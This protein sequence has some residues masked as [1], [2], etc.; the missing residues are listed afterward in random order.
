MWYIIA[1]CGGFQ[2]QALIIDHLVNTFSL[3]LYR[4]IF[5]LLE[6]SSLAFA[7]KEQYLNNYK[8]LHHVRHTVG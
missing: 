5:Q 3:T 7:L 8:R 1:S 6:G 2:W 4:R